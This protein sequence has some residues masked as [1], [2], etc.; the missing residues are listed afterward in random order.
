M[1]VYDIS[2]LQQQD[3][4]VFCILQ[5]KVL[6]LCNIGLHYCIQQANFLNG[7]CLNMGITDA[8]AVVRS[9]AAS[10]VTKQQQSKRVTPHLIAG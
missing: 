7:M 9:A 5:I 8:Y 3:S 4:G 2:E 10:Q 6:I 1:C